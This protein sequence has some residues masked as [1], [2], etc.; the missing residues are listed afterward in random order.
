MSRIS[1]KT[2]LTS[3]LAVLLAFTACNKQFEMDL[4]LAIN[5]R[6]IDLDEASG[7]THI[8]VYANGTW[9][10]KFTEPV[11]WASLDRLEGSGNSE[12]VLSYAANYGL[13]RRLSIAL[14]KDE[15]ADTIV[16][17]Q[18]GALD[19][20][21]L[22][23]PCT[24]VA[25]CKDSGKVGMKI[26]SNLYYSL[27]NVACTIKYENDD[28]AGW[29]TDVAMDGRKLL[30]N[31]SENASS[32]SRTAY[33]DFTVSIPGDS[34]TD[35]DSNVFT[36][37]V[38][39]SGADASLTLGTLD[40]VEGVNYG[41]TLKADN[42]IW[43]YSNVTCTVDYGTTVAPED[44]W[45]SDI[46]LSEDSFDFNVADNLTGDSRSATI[47]VIY[48]GTVIAELPVKQDVRPV[49]F[50]Q[51]R[52]Y[53]PGVLSDKG[54]IVGYVVSE[55][56]SENICPN[57]QTA[58]FMFDF[59]A[60][61]K[62]AVIESLD[63]KYGFLLKFDNAEDNTLKRYSKVRI[64][65]QGLTLVRQASPECYSLTGLKAENI[66]SAEEP[67]ADA[68][69][70]KHV[71]IDELTDAD[72]YTQV[73]LENV[74]IVFKDGSY[75]NCTDGYSV[76][77]SVNVA[78]S[79][80]A[81]RWDTAPLLLTDDGGNTISMLTNA[82]VDWR[83]DGTGVAQGS[84]AYTGIVVAETLVRFGDI[85]HYQIRPMVESDIALDNAPFS[86]TL[87]E[88]NWND[89]KSDL[90]P[91]VG[92]GTIS[93]VTVGLTQDYNAL[94]HN[95]AST[96]RTEKGSGVGNK[97]CVN[98]QAANLK[99]DNSSATWEVGSHFDVNFSTEG[100][101]GSLLQFGF[102][103]GHGSGNNTTLNAPSHWKLLYS[104][105]GENFTEF[106]PM[107]KNRSIVWWTTTSQDATPGYTEHLFTLP[108]ECFGQPS[109]TVRFQVA[110][111][112]CDVDPKATASNWATALGIEKGTFTSSNIALR[113]G[114]ITVRYK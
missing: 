107:V 106:V 91:E 46:S 87:V 14:S 52:G 98:N 56:G 85:G 76:K 45:I 41:I 24:K 110:D 102:V 79:S 16:V 108:S 114:T 33:V 51:L 89:A 20:A 26:S 30:M 60:N 103:W 21:S 101:S 83:R 62:A 80:T 48:N 17:N 70:V 1:I 75:T 96:S 81:P 54:F 39:Q 55:N 65:L 77:T 19:A 112:V 25:L 64:N 34:T 86:K 95:N 47:K 31:V 97:G 28:Q 18:A 42:N 6:E 66:V 78:G 40:V 7:S 10:A 57:P 92:K 15:Y 69:P 12:I 36:L 90:T 32:S 113:F 13:P 22:A 11:E 58:Q 8:L 9:N 29:I 100:I 82:K 44:E 59:T 4:P 68:V 72:I 99:S 88:W 63:G 73:V 104:I 43:A 94:V 111:N 49:S 105:D 27:Q 71:R 5:S 74:E 50:D 53:T 38:V 84:G 2:I 3:F 37:E 23:W 67:A 93:G 61:S 109:V 35:D